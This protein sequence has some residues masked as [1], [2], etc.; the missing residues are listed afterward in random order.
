MAKQTGLNR[1][2]ES[3]GAGLGQLQAKYDAWIRQRG[4]LAEELKT[5]VD[6]AQDLLQGLGHKAEDAI[7]EAKAAVATVQVA[8]KRTLSEAH[9]KAISDAA[10][11][12][13]EAKRVQAAE[14]ATVVATAPK[15]RNLS[16]EIRERLSQAATA[17]WAKAKKANKTRLG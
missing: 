16:P 11:A 1:T 12:R 13:A 17:R 15:K 3:I 4:E 2:A 8:R 6:I 14:L 9:K 7:A 5:Y 10:K